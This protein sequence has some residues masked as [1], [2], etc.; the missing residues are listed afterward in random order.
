MQNFSS[1]G[2]VSQNNQ[3]EVRK[4]RPQTGLELENVGERLRLVG[5]WYGIGV[6]YGVLGFKG[7]GESGE[8][9]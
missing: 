8:V 4:I 1:G 3:R 6:W 5:V 2:R 7:V 9:G